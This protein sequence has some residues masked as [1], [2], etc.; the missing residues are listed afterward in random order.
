MNAS[1]ELVIT[2]CGVQLTVPE[3]NLSGHCH[4]D[5]AFEL[6]TERVDSPSLSPNS[7][8]ASP[9][10]RAI[11]HGAKFYS[12]QPAVVKLP[13]NLIID[14]DCT[15]RCYE[16]DTDLD[17]VEEWRET[18]QFEI[19]GGFLFINT[20]HFSLFCAVASKQY[21][22]IEKT[23]KASEGGSLVSE[24]IPGLEVKFP[25]T[26]LEDDI[27]ATMTPLYDDPRYILSNTDK[28]LV[29]PIVALGPSGR[30]FR[31][32]VTVTLPVPDVHEEFAIEN[33]N[34][35]TIMESQTDIDEKPRW[36]KL[37]VPYVITEV[38]NIY[39]VS[40]KVRH[41]TL[42]SVYSSFRNKLGSAVNT[43][44]RTA[45]S[46]MPDFTYLVYFQAL[47]GDCNRKNQFG[48][49]VFCHRAGE[50]PITDCNDYQI[51]VGKTGQKELKTGDITLR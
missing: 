42:Y 49:Y 5:F 22:R 26:S 31:D 48:L 16:S 18:T 25:N 20:C 40:F 51:Q 44:K 28:S 3:L 24:N 2:Q 17:D 30:T 35:L 46:F 34:G 9:I 38:N 47:M 6:V 19:N 50:P 8:V 45:H 15:L 12:S 10:V 36:K 43:I 32:D 1:K 37:Q 4:S 11:P 14:E 27:K 13:L 7:I 29:S 21:P 39:T 41:F 33:D 23:V